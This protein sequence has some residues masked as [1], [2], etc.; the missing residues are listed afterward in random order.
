[1]IATEI[2]NGM[3]D[4]INKTRGAET[5]NLFMLDVL[6]GLTKFSCVQQHLLSLIPISEFKPEWVLEN[7]EFRKW[8][9]KNIP[10]DQVSEEWLVL[11]GDKK[12]FFE[13]KKEEKII[14]T[15]MRD[16]NRNRR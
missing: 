9:V 13:R 15:Y 7:D 14:R 5:A 16:V 6:C 10:V 11:D 12:I 2:Q 8:C 3:F 4:Y 1:M